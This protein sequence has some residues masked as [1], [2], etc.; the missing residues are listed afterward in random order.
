MRKP[1]NL[2]SLALCLGMAAGVNAST[3]TQDMVVHLKFDNQWTDASGRGNDATAVGEPTFAAG[4]VGTKALSVI[5]AKDGS[6]FNYATLPMNDDLTLGDATS[7]SVAF[8]TKLTDW[9]GDPAFISNKNWGGGANQ[10]W[11]VAASGDGHLQWNFKAA[12]TSRADYDGPSGLFSDHNWHHIALT[13]DRLGDLITYVDGQQVNT[14]SIAANTGIID[15]GMPI[16]I[17]QD[18]TGTYTDGG[19]VGIT[20]G[21]IDDLGIWRRVL[22][23]SE[24]GRIFQAGQAGTSISDIPDPST[25]YVG[26]ASISDGGANIRPSAVVQFDVINASTKLNTN[27]VSLTFDNQKVTPTITSASDTNTIVAYDPPGLLAPKSTHSIKFI[28]ANDATP[29]VY[30]TNDIQF[31]VSDYAQITLPTPL[32]LETFD[33]LQDGELPAGWSVTNLTT[34]VYAGPDFTERRSD[35]FMDWVVLTPP[36]FDL[37]AANLTDAYAL[38]N[39]APDV[40]VNGALVTNLMRTNFILGISDGRSGSQIQYLFSKDYDLTGKSNIVVA[41]NS[42]FIQNQDS[43]GALEYSIDAGKTWLPIVYMIFSGDIVKDTTGAIDAV[44]TMTNVYSDVATYVDADTGETKG[45][46]YG[47]FI[48]APISASLAPYISGRADDDKTSSMKVEMFSLPAASNQGKVRFRFAQTG[49]DSWFWGIDDFGLY[50]ITTIAPPTVTMAAATVSVGIGNS[51]TLTPKVEGTGPFTYQWQFNSK[52][53]AGETNSSLTIGNV[54][55][56]SAGSYQVKV[57]NVGG[58]VTSPV[59]TLAPY[60]PATS[61]TGQWDFDLGSLK[62]TVG[63]DLEY[64]AEDVASATQ[65]GTTTSFGIANINGKEAKVMAVPGL[66]PLNGYI[67][68]HGAAANGGG[69]NVNQYT[70]IFDILYPAE[71]DGK[72]RALLQIDP[73][74]TSDSDFFVN[75]GGGLGIS[76]VYPG[77]ILPDTWNRI[78]LAVD[79]TVPV[80][81][82]FINGEKVGEQTLSAGKD[83]R[84]SLFPSTDANTPYAL[85]FADED[86]EDALA[87]VNS[88]QFWSGRLSD[89]TLVA[90]GNSHS[91]RIAFA[92][93]PDH[94]QSDPYGHDDHD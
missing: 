82:K 29:A 86:G 11:V 63:N 30:K 80:V 69:T 71:S 3:I 53:I 2:P 42:M 74:N 7:F 34:Q 35:S 13:F 5:T 10:G 41:Y 84:W 75:G 22:N 18:G 88:I 73:N 59:L 93:K 66:N 9:T 78:A 46:S 61:L 68:K 12:D 26:T 94:D 72:Y 19:S 25:P 52:D 90:L 24:I 60:V 31:T 14:T 77:K 79:L 64:K 16:N 33:S 89:A 43:S 28:F 54:K 45:G 50:S 27:T 76:A 4:K 8:W 70:L 6:S 20:D 38:T 83:G 47:S 65:F 67:M 21:Q 57:T 39:V 17:G 91:R 23:A 1:I 56:A 49:T 87:Y 32:Y 48:G 36:T 44:A 92:F 40:Y 62:A 58:T 51:I 85:L 81:A 55:T 37:F 15:S